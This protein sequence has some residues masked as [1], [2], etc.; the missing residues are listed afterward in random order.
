VVGVGSEERHASHPL[1]SIVRHEPPAH[2]RRY[3]LHG[4]QATSR[5]RRIM[6][7]QSFGTPAGAS[8]ASKVRYPSWGVWGV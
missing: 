1:A 4:I 3:S 6:A 5:D 2:Q 7:R 8:G